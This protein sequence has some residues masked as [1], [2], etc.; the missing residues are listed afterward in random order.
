MG[1]LP[2]PD[3]A[4]ILGRVV[5]GT[6]PYGADASRW[7]VGRAEA[8]LVSRYGFLAPSETGLTGAQFDPPAGAFLVARPETA[9]PPVGG[10][11]LRGISPGLGEVR[12]LWVDPDWRC[13]GVAHDLMAALEGIARDLGLRTLRLA[14]GTRQPE[15]V[16]LYAGSGWQRRQDDWDGTPLPDGCIPF[17]KEVAR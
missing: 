13:L 6:E 7:V 5:V 11:G 10:V 14:T 2:S 3:A 17:T 15:A 9:G 1:H 16:D 4:A 12:R 8:E